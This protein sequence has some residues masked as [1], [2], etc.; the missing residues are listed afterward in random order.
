MD[1]WL[2][3]KKTIQRSKR[4]YAHFDVRT[5]IGRMKD[6]V[7]NPKAVAAHGFYPFIH[8]EMDMSKF[9]RGKGVVPKKRD[10]CYAA[11]IDR[12]IYQYYSHIL[13][14]KYNERTT[15]DGISNVAV[16]YR[17]NLRKSNIQFSKAA[18]DFIR[19]TENCY[20]MIGDF[21]HFFDNLDHAYLKKQWCS[22]LE[23]ERLPKD[24]YNVFKNITSFSQWELTDLLL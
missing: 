5:D 14:E 16:A 7:S 13:N 15:C 10:I 19:K 3:D 20:V 8:Y 18:Y 21:T 17:T 12:C 23:C 1:A 2:S 24:H 11:H 4:Y 9:K 6:Y 22:L